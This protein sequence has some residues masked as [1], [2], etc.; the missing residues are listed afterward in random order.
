[1]GKTVGVKPLMKSL[2]VT[3][4]AHKHLSPRIPERLVSGINLYYYPIIGTYVSSGKKTMK[5]FVHWSTTKQ[6][7]APSCCCMLLGSRIF[8]YQSFSKGSFTEALV[9]CQCRRQRRCG[10]NP[11]VRKIPWRRK[12]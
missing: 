6:C 11:W 12:W 10:F 1:M 5:G 9:T 3:M 2:Q 8:S 4:C 7:M